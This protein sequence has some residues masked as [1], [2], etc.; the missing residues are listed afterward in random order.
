MLATSRQHVMSFVLRQL[1][2]E[3]PLIEPKWLQKGL[4]QHCL[5]Y[6]LLGMTRLVA[7]MI[8]TNTIGVQVQVGSCFD[9]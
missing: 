8:S 7:T 6:S 3:R 5:G 1:A 9:P 4:M 2:K